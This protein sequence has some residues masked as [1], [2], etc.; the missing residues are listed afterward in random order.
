MNLS[1]FEN[2]KKNNRLGH[3]YLITGKPSLN[4]LSLAHEVCYLVLKDYDNN[5]NLKTLI[6]NN[7]YFQIFHINSEGSTIKKDQIIALQQAFSKTSLIK[8][9]RF[10][11]IEDVDLI[12][13]QAAN[14]L[15]KFMEEP[16]NSMVYGLLTS[17]NLQGVL[18][19]I[20]SRSQIVRMK[21][22]N[23]EVAKHLINENHDSFVSYNISALTNDLSEA[24]ELINNPSIMEVIDYLKAY[25]SNFTNASYQ[26][27][28]EFN[29]QLNN[30]IVDRKLYKIFLELLLYNYTD[31][32]KFFLGED[33][34]FIYDDLVKNITSENLLKD[35]KLIKEE[36][37][38]QNA[39]ININISVDALLIQL[40]RWD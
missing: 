22:V 12:S 19:T 13:T 34:L 31:L 40:K 36:I 20:T 3:L 33:H 38:R 1:I 7:E 32:L 2:A 6:N 23:N 4:K 5:P 28:L 10:Y 14:S 17:S 21:D 24:F 25:F 35:I 29:K 11:I 39:Y 15:L 8:G 26:I 27:L 37:K 18:P 30:L 16:E 9:P